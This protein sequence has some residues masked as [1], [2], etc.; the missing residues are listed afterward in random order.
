MSVAAPAAPAVPKRRFRLKRVLVGALAILVIGAFANLVGW[1]LSGW[2]SNL[3]D[4]ISEISI[5][6]LIAGVTLTRSC[7]S[8][9][10]TQ[11]AGVTSGP[12]TR[13]PLRSTASSRRTSGRS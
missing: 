3:W 1:D 2:F 10:P 13:P 11:S 9:T 8:R 12:V 4:T 7:A 5:G 6:Y